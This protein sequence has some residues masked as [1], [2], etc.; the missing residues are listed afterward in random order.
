MTACLSSP[1]EDTGDDR[2][3]AGFDFHLV[4]PLELARL[5]ELLAGL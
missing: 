2:G 5:R 4:K 3:R 1:R